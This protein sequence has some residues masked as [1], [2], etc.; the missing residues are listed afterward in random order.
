ML[1]HLHIQN[2]ALISH[3][4]IDF[5]SGFSVLTGETGAGKSII[6]GALALVLGARADSKAITDGEDKCIIEAEFDE[7]IIR[8]EL[9]ANGKSRSFVDD[10]VVTLQELKAL[11]TRL[12]DIHSQHANLLIENPDFQLE[13]VDAVAS[14]E[15]I[16][17][18]Y[19]TQYEQ[20]TAA[21]QALK[22]LQALARKS[23]Q[24]AD[25][26][27]YRYKLLDEAALQE[28]E[29]EQLEQEQY[30][31]SHAE[32]IRAALELAVQ[33]LN[34]EQGSAIDALRTCRLDEAAPELQERIDSARIELQDIAEEA[35]RTLN[36]VEMDPRRLQWIEERLDTLNGLLH[37]FS[38]ETIEE[39]IATREE[40]AQQV[41][42]L[43]SFDFDIAQAEKNLN[44]KRSAL[45]QTAK[46]LTQSR[47]TIIPSIC[48]RLI[49][50][51][52][53][54]GVAHANIDILVNP[55]TD[56]TPSG[57]D[58]VQ[59]RF[60]ANLNQSLRAVSEVASGGEISRLMLCVKSLIA[61]T[62]G[63]PTI[64]FDEIDTGVSG[65]I[66]TQMATIMR[67]MAQ[68]RQIIAITHLPQIAAL[69]QTHYKVF[70][71][72][73]ETRTE[74][75]IRLLT[76]EERITEIASM[77]SGNNVTQA[78]KNTAKELLNEQIND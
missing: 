70:K 32:D 21:L 64:I 72:D 53:Q 52:K 61:S 69:G 3:L 13:I 1:K 62:K 33:A 35:E 2:Y 19:T 57:C 55:T 37:K 78:A 45:T 47:Q 7:G 9:Y 38:A 49:A 6:L 26:I 34:G 77:L 18:T 74:T 11:S 27:Q 14:N 23:Q 76:N 60:A 66:A 67:E 28:S 63:L 31:L 43:D 39:L 73:T 56:F 30:R 71:A 50:G 75:H 29:L 48:Q 51:M 20:Y 40:L 54:L 58:E 24:D 25:Y 42:R 44:A 5:G 65:D 36:R 8:R 59:I 10:S 68:H 46:A 22:D 12:I 4:D 15:S 41:N 17:T 16:K